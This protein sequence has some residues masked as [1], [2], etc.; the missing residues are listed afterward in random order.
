MTLEQYSIIIYIESF[1]YDLEQIFSQ[2]FK[3]PFFHSHASKPLSDAT[4]DICL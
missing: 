3:Q 1:Q 4:C 2:A